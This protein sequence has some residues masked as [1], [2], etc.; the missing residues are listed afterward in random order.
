MTRLAPF[1]LLPLLAAC[2]PR[3]PMDPL[4]AARLCEDRARAAAGPT[5]GVAVGAN[6]ADGPFADVAI[7]LSSDY[8]AGRDPLE[9]Y[10]TCVVERTGAEPVRPP[11]L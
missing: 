5:G 10:R 4:A 11:A 6:S 9:V 2:G 3:P 7:S 1:L 8:I